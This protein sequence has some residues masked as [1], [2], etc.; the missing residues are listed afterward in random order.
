MT[1]QPWSCRS[2][3]SDGPAMHINFL[4]NFNNTLTQHTKTPL[5]TDGCISCGAQPTS[6]CVLIVQCER[7][8]LEHRLSPHCKRLC[9]HAW[10]SGP[11]SHEAHVDDSR[12]YFHVSRHLDILCIAG[13]ACVAQYCVLG[14]RHGEHASHDWRDC[15]G[16][17]QSLS[18]MWS[19]F[20]QSGRESLF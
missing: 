14:G 8:A 15:D 19:E 3:R 17:L 20:G 18:R 10:E 12:C 2:A 7:L 5:G 4:V 13:E 16:S 6:L 9:P 1:L 11:T